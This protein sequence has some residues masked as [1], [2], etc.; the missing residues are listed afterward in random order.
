MRPSNAAITARYVSGPIDMVIFNFTDK[1]LHNNA[2][3]LAFIY[4]TTVR[5]ILRQDV[6]SI[7]RETAQRCGCFRDLRSW[8]HVRCQPRL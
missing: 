7:L 5:A 8:L 6:R 1:N 2:A 4:D 3:D